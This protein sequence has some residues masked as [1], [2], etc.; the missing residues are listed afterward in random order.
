MQRF[1]ATLLDMAAG[2]F[3]EGCMSLLVKQGFTHDQAD[4][5]IADT[6]HQALASK[7]KQFHD[8]GDR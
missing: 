7:R 2:K 1:A 6:W 4:R 5:I 3:R 8:R